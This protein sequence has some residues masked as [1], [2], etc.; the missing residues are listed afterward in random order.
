MNE[1]GD[2]EGYRYKILTDGDAKKQ[3]QVKVKRK[4][5]KKDNQ[6]TIIR[7][8]TDEDTVEVVDPEGGFFFIDT[9]GDPLYVID[10]KIASK[11]DVK[12]LDPKDIM[13]I[14][15]RKGDAAEEK[16][17]KKAKNGVVEIITKQ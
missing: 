14:D 7:T 13:T 8:D 2:H 6:V 17:G 9:D 3:K 15:V 10:G 5:S 11:K 4:Q 12:K 16:Y 1:D